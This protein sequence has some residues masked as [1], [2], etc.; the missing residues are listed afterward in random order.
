[1]SPKLRKS[2]LAL[3][4]GGL[5]AVVLVI[6]GINVKLAMRPEA[7]QARVRA[8]LEKLLRVPFEIGSAELDLSD[9]VS[10]SGLR[11]FEPARGD[12]E[13]AALLEFPRIR[14]VPDYGS[15][16]FGSFEPALVVLDG[17]EIDASISEEGVLNLA[18]LLR[19]PPPSGSGEGKVPGVAGSQARLPDFRVRGLRVRFA[20]KRRSLALAAEEVDFSLGLARNTGQLLFNSAF[21]LADSSRVEISGRL[22][23]GAASVADGPLEANFMIYKFDLAGDLASLLDDLAAGKRLKERSFSGS[24]DLEGSL[25]Y[26]RSSGLEVTRVSSSLAGCGLQLPVIE[27]TLRLTGGSAVF[28]GDRIEIRDARGELAGGSLSAAGSVGIDP[29]RGVVTTLKGSLGGEGLFVDEKLLAALAPELN[30]SIPGSV[31]RGR[32]NFVCEAAEAV[33]YPPA[34]ENLSASVEL[35]EFQIVHGELPYPVEEF[36]GGLKLEKGLLKLGEK[37]TGKLG[38]ARLVVSELSG[39]VDGS[40][41]FEAVV[42][43]GG[44]DPA[45]CLAL[46]GQ[47]RGFLGERGEDGVKVWD[48][49]APEGWV[50]A[51]ARIVAEP[52]A[53][54]GGK[55]PAPYAIFSVYPRELKIRHRLFP[56]TVEKISGEAVYDS[57]RPESG[58]LLNIEGLHGGQK[59]ACKGSFDVH[60]GPAEENEDP[61]GFEINITSPQLQYDKDIRAA[62]QP[63]VS[64]MVDTF[65]FKGA[66]KTDVSIGSRYSGS[67]RLKVVLDL[68]KG[69]I[70]AVDFPY[71]LQ[72]A[73]GRIVIDNNETILLS[74]FKTAGGVGAQVSFDGSLRR[75]NDTRKLEYRLLLGDF[76]LDEQFREAFPA[77]YQNFLNGLGLEGTF[78][79]R[80]AGWYLKNLTDS[81]ND[82]H[83]FEGTDIRTRDAAVNFGVKV[84]QMDAQG[85]FTGGHNADRPNHFWGEVKVEKA[86]FNRLQLKDG[87]IVFTFGEQHDRIRRL[88]DSVDTPGEKGPYLSSSI[89]G[90]L[91]RGDVTDTFQ[92]SIASE[93]FYKGRL[94]GM[95]YVDT[96]EKEGDLGGEFA[97]SGISLAEASVDVFGGR[98]DAIRG[99]ASGT[100]FFAGKTGD[101][102]SIRGEG[103]GLIKEA[104]LAELP[105]FL[106][107]FKLF[108]VPDLINLGFSDLLLRSKL[109]N[110]KIPYTIED[111]RFLT[112]GLEMNSSNSGLSFSGVGS[113]DF[114]G[115][116]ALELEPQL[117][118]SR[119]KLPL[120]PDLIDLTGIDLNKIFSF[121][122]KGIL[123]IK[124]GGDLARPRAELATGLG[125]IKVPIDPGLP[126]K[127]GDDGAKKPP[128][129][130]SPGEE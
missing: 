27:K 23:G 42:D 47:L 44:E 52:P 120:I 117:P 15:L 67:P 90:R 106:D 55:R 128:P 69:E 10:L 101:Q 105:L 62:L 37:L 18:E 9:G 19:A 114:D 103:V 122:K 7:V 12:R 74:G 87:D 34:L 119:L 50:A 85:R 54:A 80:L 70:Q 5:L 30:K 13:P 61:P 1:M 129:G 100:V 31:I 49:L 75:L 96:G 56:Y 79:G 58:I 110:V 14:I 118:T 98:K 4:L 130:D 6:V 95:L 59:I 35:S 43:V 3:V 91:A 48:S 81:A 99:T 123:K 93:N 24:V 39:L 60:A 121:I 28:L 115:N 66:F 65:A 40:G 45:E 17:G 71:R 26:D 109:D 51:K 83:Y 38:A 94:D 108:K 63:E 2:R 53:A 78:S 68:L 29:A 57:R 33:K 36:A 25:R 113:M 116:L 8:V 88:A 104:N 77:Q 46:D 92:M 86:R 76:K 64:R 21:S 126:E 97:A 84:S 73:T 124:I 20:D 32:V 127:K 111:G 112:E 11:V 107:I 89:I 102:R 22:P 125:L 72:L 16:F 41:V 82:K